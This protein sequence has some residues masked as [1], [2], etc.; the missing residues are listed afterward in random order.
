MQCCQ[1]GVKE[2]GGKIRM[3]GSFPDR[4]FDLQQRISRLRR[5]WWTVRARL[6]G[7]HLSKR[8]QARV[9]EACVESTALFDA[10][11]RQWYQRELQR[12]QSEIDRCY[13]WI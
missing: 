11:V 2:S 3:L 6:R 10:G 5:S 4:H 13:R 7:S 8:T 12:L 9:V 1:G